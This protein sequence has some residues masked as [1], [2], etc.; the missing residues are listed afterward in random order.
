MTKFKP[1]TN[2]NI[3]VDKKA[4]LTV[5]KKHSDTLNEIYKEECKLPE[6]EKELLSLKEEKERTN[7][8]KDRIIQ[9]NKEIKRI[10]E[11]RQ[12]YYLNHSKYIFNYFESKKCDNIST[13]NNKKT[14]MNSFFNVE[15][16]NAN[17]RPNSDNDDDINY[18]TNTMSPL[19]E[20]PKQYFSHLDESFIDMNDYTESFDTC[21]KCNAEMTS[22]EQDGIIVCT[23]CFEHKEYLIDH[24]KPSYKEPPKE[25]SFYAYKR[26]NHFREI[27]AQFQAKESTH[28]DDEVI[29][30]IKKQIKKERIDLSKLTNTK[31]K[32]ILKRL[33]YNKYYEHISFI[34]EKLGIYP[35]RMSAELEQRLCTLFMEIQK[36]YSK[37]C[38]TNRVNFLNY[39]YVLYKLCELL[40]EDAYLPYFYMLKD[41]EKRNEQD[42]IWKLIC[43]D[44]KWEFIRT[45]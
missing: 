21:K 45:L 17:I 13:S 19:T 26:I 14:V 36:P 8:I 20:D 39:Y 38:P 43:K 23:K 30:N 35:P 31:T 1:K 22:V 10:K 27:L 24:N 37:Y 33:G 44:L 7:D 25:V 3:K 28:I 4:I 34:K 29:E 41:D 18:N 42:E 9:I 12:A 11:L 6:L 5:D 2:K 15:N 32:Q 40:R 16:S